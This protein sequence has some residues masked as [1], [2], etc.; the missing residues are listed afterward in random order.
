[1]GTAAEVGVGEDIGGADVSLAHALSKRTRMGAAA[2]RKRRIPGD[3]S[4]LR[5]RDSLC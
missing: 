3:Y 2:L 5:Q 1:M 4:T